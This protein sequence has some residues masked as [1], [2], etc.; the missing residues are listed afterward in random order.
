MDILVVGMRNIV[1]IDGSEPGMSTRVHHD[2]SFEIRGVAPGIP[3]GKPYNEFAMLLKGVVDGF[4]VFLI[5]VSEVPG[6]IVYDILAA[7]K[8]PLGIEGHVCHGSK[9]GIR[10]EREDRDRKT[11]VYNLYPNGTIVEGPVRIVSGGQSDC[12]ITRL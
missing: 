9:I 8:A 1:E 10:I 5:T 4:S 11:I 7:V 6:V 3:D 2:R 12:V